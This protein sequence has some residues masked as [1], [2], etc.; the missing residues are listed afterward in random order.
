MWLALA[1]GILEYAAVV[2]KSEAFAKMWCCFLPPL[3]WKQSVPH[4]KNNL[5]LASESRDMR[6]AHKEDGAGVRVT[7]RGQTTLGWCSSPSSGDASWLLSN[8]WTI[9]DDGESH[10][11]Y[12]QP[13]SSQMAS[14]RLCGCLESTHR[15]QKDGSTCKDALASLMTWINPWSPYD[16]KRELLRPPHHAWH[17]P[18]P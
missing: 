10:W 1:N 7:C 18:Y 13:C 17:T 16:R 2:M 12:D 3:L 6:W 14:F 11:Q 15:G 5:C 4:T 9:V 8:S